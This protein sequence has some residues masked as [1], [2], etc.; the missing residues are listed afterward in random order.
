MKHLW[1]LG[2]SAILGLAA[3]GEQKAAQQQSTAAPVALMS[4]NNTSQ[5]EATDEEET[6][7]P[8]KAKTKKSAE[9]TIPAEPVDI[10]TATADELIVALKGTGVGKAKVAKIIEYREQNKG[11]KSIEELS[12]VKGIGSK[13]VEKMRNRIKISAIDDKAPKKAVSIT[14]TEQ[15]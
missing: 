7:K 9:N 4:E 5:I 10:N 6:S 15:K 14:E 1:I 8:K 13:T 2:L 11:F 3:C 12:E